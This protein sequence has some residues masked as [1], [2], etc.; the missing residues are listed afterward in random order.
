MYTLN[1]EGE[2]EVFINVVSDTRQR[3]GST[4]SIWG[5]FNAQIGTDNETLKGVIGRHGDPG[6]TDNGGYLL[7]FCCIVGLDEQRCEETVCIQLGNKAPT[8]S[9]SF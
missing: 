3:I 7:Q 2:Y 8:T 9:K 5:Y 1:V 4:E 6:F